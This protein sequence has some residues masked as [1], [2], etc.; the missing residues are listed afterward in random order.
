MPAFFAAGCC[1]T[2]PLM[3][4]FGLTLGETS[5]YPYRW[6]FRLGGLVIFVVSLWWYFRKQGLL[7][8]DDY[9]K[10]KHIVLFI[11]G[12]TAL[13]SSI[14]YLFLLY[15]VAPYMYQAVLEQ[16]SCCGF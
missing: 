16:A 13:Y 8:W 1:A 5:L 9:Q 10:E 12:Q 7:Q 15:A 6:L 2:V 11:I 3:V 14:L 4:M